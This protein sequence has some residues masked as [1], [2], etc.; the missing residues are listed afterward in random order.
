MRYDAIA[1]LGGVSRNAVI[2]VIYR[3][4]EI[5]R[6]RHRQEQLAALRVAE[7]EASIEARFPEPARQCLIAE[8]RAAAALGPVYPSACRPAP[9]NRER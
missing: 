6:G 1:R 9:V 8:V 5:E 4:R 2:G 7:V 3:H